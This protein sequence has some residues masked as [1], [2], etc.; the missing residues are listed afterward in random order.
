MPE[1]EP[2]DF[3]SARCERP[4]EYL[5]FDAANHAAQDLRLRYIDEMVK[6][7]DDVAAAFS[8]SAA[9][10][11]ADRVAAKYAAADAN[12]KG[13]VEGRKDLHYAAGDTRYNVDADSDGKNDMAEAVEDGIQGLRNATS[14]HEVRVAKQV[15]QKGGLQRFVYL[16]VIEELKKPSKQ[17]YD[18]AYGYLGTGPTNAAPRGMAALA[19]SRDGNNGTT[20]QSELFSMVLDGACTL[21]KATFRLNK[22]AFELSEDS[23]YAAH[24]TLMDERLQVLFAY[25][26]GHEL[27]D[28]VVAQNNPATSHVKMAEAEGF[29]ATL[30][31]YLLQAGGQRAQFAADLEREINEAKA[32]LN[33]STWPSRFP[34]AQLL[35]TLEAL[36]GI[37]VKA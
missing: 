29:L 30:K 18:E 11:A 13:K 1:P 26:V 33:T 27:H 35:Q 28:M 37:D 24:V 5:A 7:F 12:L 21:E 2:Q 25:S 17:H 15:F 23:D 36:Y 20:L 34:A 14:A 19:K 10:A 4:A 3:S 6:E 32:E 22:D 31:P 16:S 8:T 9:A